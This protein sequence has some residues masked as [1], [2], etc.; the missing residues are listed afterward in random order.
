M[1]IE[2]SNNNNNDQRTAYAYSSNVCIDFNFRKIIFNFVPKCFLLGFIFDLIIFDLVES[3]KIETKTLG[4]FHADSY[5]MD[6]N[7]FQESLS[8]LI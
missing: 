1:N 8:L 6:F 2:F 3:S 7:K 5:G 4:S